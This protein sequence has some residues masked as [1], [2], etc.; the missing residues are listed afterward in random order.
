MMLNLYLSKY[1]ALQTAKRA[2]W[3][4]ELQD[5]QTVNTSLLLAKDVIM[6]AISRLVT[7]A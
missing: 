7:S 4:Y 6:H 2:S 3:M 5:C 1:A